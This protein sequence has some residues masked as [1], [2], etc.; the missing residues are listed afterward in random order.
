MESKHTLKSTSECINKDCIIVTLIANYDTGTTCSLMT[1]VVY[2]VA[3]VHCLIVC[4][5]L[6]MY[7]LLVLNADC[8][9]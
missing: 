8:L 5:R 1:D 9:K 6:C 7:Q 3:V 4:T 2:I